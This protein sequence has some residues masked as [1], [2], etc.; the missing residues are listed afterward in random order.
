MF[1]K[2]VVISIYIYI[3]MSSEVKVFKIVLEKNGNTVI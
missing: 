3:I 1:R 2:Y